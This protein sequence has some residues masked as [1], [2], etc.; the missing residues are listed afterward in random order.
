MGTSTREALKP[1]I[2]S[3]LGYDAGGG[4]EYSSRTMS[5]E[6]SQ[7]AVLAKFGMTVLSRDPVIALMKML[8]TA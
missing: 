4:L 2:E 3:G 8:H 1:I 6:A 7:T 5:G